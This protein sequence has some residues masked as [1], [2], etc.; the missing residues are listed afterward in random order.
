MAKLVFT[1]AY[2]ELG[3][4]TLSDQVRSVTLNYSA[5]EVEA[6]CMTQAGVARLGGLKDWSAD[7]EFA[8]N[9]ASSKADAVVGPLVGT[10]VAF[11]IRATTAAIGAT[12]PAYSGVG[13]IFEYSPLS[14]TVG[15]LAVA[16]VT[17]KGSDG[18]ALSRGTT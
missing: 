12:N 7:I 14:G 16:P 4:T 9:F 6:T 1:N 15:D 3:G 5:A 11:L 18:N 10:T 17:V 2:L 13:I 8:Q